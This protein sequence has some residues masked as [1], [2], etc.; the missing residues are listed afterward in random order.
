MEQLGDI[1]ES[2]IRRSLRSKNFSTGDLR[3]ANYD[4]SEEPRSKRRRT[5]PDI[6]A[7]DDN[8]HDDDDDDGKVGM[9]SRQMI[10]ISHE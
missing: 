2:G 7:N 1:E 10:G 9:S 4:R 6:A 5:D 3:R 8:D